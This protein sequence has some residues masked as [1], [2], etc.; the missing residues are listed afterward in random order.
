MSETGTGPLAG[1]RVIELAGLGPAGFGAML[2][3]DLGADIVRIDRPPAPRSLITMDGPMSRGRRSIALDLKD[4]EDREAAFALIDDADVLIDPF[5]PGVTERL[6]LGPDIAL[7]RNPRLVYARMTGWGQDG[8]LAQRAGHDL[9]YLALSGAL[10]MMGTPGQP[11][12]VPLNLIGDFGGGG[13]LLGFG[14]VSALYERDRSGVGQVLDVAMLDGVL[15]LSASLFQLRAE[16]L[17]HTERGQSFL[18]GGAPWY[19]AY[20]AQDGRYLTVGA[21]EPQFYRLLLRSLDIDESE[22]PQWDRDRWPALTTLLERLFGGRPLRYWVELLGDTDV[23]FAPVLDIDD[24][25]SHPHHAAR[26]TVS[27]AFGMRQPSPA[28]RFSR[29][30][31]R[32]QGPSVTPGEHT[33]DILAEIKESSHD[34]R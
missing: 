8:P 7:E 5:R 29:T 30:P 4:D 16:G 14:I 1:V 21:L 32:I 23:C 2:L 31:G 3:S 28:P 18:D 33:A 10:A 13:M 15:L 34:G 22:Y 6:G 24:L 19:R 9:N 27:S 12:P 26:G 17:M 11:P 25:E 20:R